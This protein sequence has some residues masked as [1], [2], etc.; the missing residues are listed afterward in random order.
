MIYIILVLS[1][2]IVFI[3]SLRGSKNQ[4]ST[5]EGY[6]MANRGMGTLALFFTIL[7][8]NFSA[9]Y[10]LGFAGAG[11]RIGYAHYIMMA[12]GTGFACLSFFIIGTPVW[13]L[14][15]QHGF[16]T[17]SELIFHQSKSKMLK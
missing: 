16:I 14:G 3:G 13:K 17:P 10:F 1:I 5:P 9:F 11:Y 2:A 12:L 8:T 15:K 6:F 7:A 4:S